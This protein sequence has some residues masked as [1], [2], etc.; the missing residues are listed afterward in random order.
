AQLQ[1]QAANPCAGIGTMR[2]APADRESSKHRERF[3]RESLRGRQRASVGAAGKRARDADA[4]GMRA[5]EAR[6]RTAVGF[7]RVDHLAGG[8]AVGAQPAS[9]PGKCTDRAECNRADAGQ[10]EGPPEA[11]RAGVGAWVGTGERLVWVVHPSLFLW[12][13]W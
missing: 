12:G 1:R 5:A 10:R 7:H 11:L 6:V 9:G 2:V 3:A 8:E 13:R 4:L